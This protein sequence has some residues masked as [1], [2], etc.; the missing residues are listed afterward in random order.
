MYECG[1]CLEE[2][3]IN[4]RVARCNLCNNYLHLTCSYKCKNKCPYCRF[5]GSSYNYSCVIIQK[6]IRR[7]LVYKKY[8]KFSSEL[9]I[10]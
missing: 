9:Y 8:L 4:S 2:I 5:S 6:Y 10:C 7:F 1:V 3:N